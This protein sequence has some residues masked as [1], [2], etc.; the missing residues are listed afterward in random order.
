MKP[1]VD[2]VFFELPTFSTLV[3][4]GATVGLIVANV[5]LRSR[6]RRAARA[7][8]FFDLAL[9]TMIV[10]WIGAR[11][12]HVALNWDYYSARPDE[13]AQIGLG[14]LAMRGA[15]IAG[16]IAIAIFARVRRVS[17][18]KIADASVLGLA[19][20]QAIGWAG[21]LAHGANYGVVSDARFALDL[22][23]LYGIVE[24]RFPVQHVE[25]VFFAAL[26]I[27]LWMLSARSPRQGTLAL[28]YWLIAS[29]AQFALGFARGDET[30]RLGGLRADQIVDAGFVIIAVVL[31]AKI[32]FA[33]SNQMTYATSNRT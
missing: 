22:P 31:F 3:M 14:G 15:F 1:T 27:G 13:I 30:V 25:I 4:L 10:A 20:G 17:F 11:A 29:L 6:V 24:P 8:M 21:A 26:F 12:Y 19:A 5:Y 7:Q 32:Y 9:V 33:P 23:D 2:F 16:A 28:T 18:R